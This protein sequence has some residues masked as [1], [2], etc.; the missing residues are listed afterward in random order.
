MS[1]TEKSLQEL[2]Q[3]TN[4]QP[5]VDVDDDGGR[6]A[7]PTP[8]ISRRT[9]LLV[10][11]ALTI[12]V[13]IWWYRQQQASDDASREI[14]AAATEP[15]DDETTGEIQ[16]PNE[17]GQPLKGDEAV[18]EALKASGHIQGAE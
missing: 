14:E 5:D 1:N 7:L 15:V 13:A 11:I 2:E 10:G 3:S 4:Q 18:I 12:A 9:L 17:R 8:S 6:F 16:V